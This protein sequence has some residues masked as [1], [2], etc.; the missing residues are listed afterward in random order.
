MSQIIIQGLLLS[1]LYSLIA[2]GFTLIFSVGRVLNLSYGGNLLLGAYAYYWAV[3]VHHAPKLVGLLFAA[4]VG[5][6]AGL[7][8]YRAVVRPLKGNMVA[9]ENATL[10]MAVVLQAMVVLIFNSSPKMLQPIVVGVWRMGATSITYNIATAMVVSW[11]ILAL[12]YLFVRHTH[13]GR[14]IQAVSMDSKGAALSGINPDWVNLMTWG[15][16][17]ALGGI[18]GVFFATYTALSP[19]MWVSP[20][21]IAIAVV[22][23]GGIGSIVGTLIVAHIIG[24][25]EVISTTLI[26]AQL[27]GVFTMLLVIVVLVVSPKGLFGREEL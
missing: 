19:P 17:G 6:F 22:I 23:V 24:F 21:I 27:R 5:M 4:V 15:I 16:S 13:A 1:G 3:Q 12:L 20:L 18:A 14:A 2:V 8:I 11:A 10:I 25:M 7:V 26:S 9:V